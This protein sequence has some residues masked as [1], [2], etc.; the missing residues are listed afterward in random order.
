MS[1]ERTAN[2]E[3]RKMAVKRGKYEI[4]HYHAFRKAG[5]YLRFNN[6]LIKLAADSN[7]FQR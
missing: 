4:M 7:T 3:E 5:R 1:A 6:L 2:E